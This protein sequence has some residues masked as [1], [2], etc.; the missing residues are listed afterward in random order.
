MGVINE[1]SDSVLVSRSFEIYNS[2]YVGYKWT[3][4]FAGQNGNV[5]P[6]LCDTKYL[7]STNSHYPAI[8]TMT[9]IQDG[10]LI[11]GLFGLNVTYPNIIE[12]P[13]SAYDSPLVPWNINGD[14][15]ANTL[16]NFT[17]FGLVSVNRIAYIPSTE[18]RWSGGYIWTV[19]FLERNGNIPRMGTLNKLTST[20]L[21]NTAEI[22]VGTQTQL[23]PQ[24]DPSTAVIGNQIYGTFGLEFYDDYGKLYNSTASFFNITNTDGHALS[25]EE[26]QAEFYTFFESQILVNVSRSATPNEVLGYTYLVTF[27]GQSVGGNVN[28][29]IP[30]TSN[31]L[32]TSTASA[33]LQ[34]GDI[35]SDALKCN[36]GSYYIN[37]DISIVEN[38]IGAQLQGTFQLRFN[39]YITSNIPYNADALTVEG[40][41]NDLLSISPSRVK[42]SRYGPIHTPFTQVFGFVWSITFDSNTWVD[43]TVNHDTYVDG[44]WIGS[45]TTW[46]DTWSTGYSKAWG[47]NVGDMPLIQCV[48]NGLYLTNGNLQSDSCVV[49]E[50]I[51]GTAPLAGTFKLGLNT[52]G[53]QV[54][55]V[56][57]NLYTRPISIN[58]FANAEDSG[59]DGT[60]LQE[61]LQALDNVGDISVTRSAVNPLNGGYTWYITFLRDQGGML[62]QF[63]Y[64]CQQRDSTYNLCNSPGDV[65]GL[66]FN[67]KSL[68]GECKSEYNSTI[69]YICPLVTVLTGDSNS[70]AQPPGSKA[71]QQIFTSNPNYDYNFAADESFTISYAP[72][73]TSTYETTACIP[74]TAPAN[75]VQ[76]AI[77]TGI[78][79]LNPLANSRGVSVTATYDDVFAPNGLVYTIYFFDEGPKN[80]FIVGACPGVGLVWNVTQESVVEGS[81]FGLTAEDMGVQ[82]GVVQRGDFTAFY[83]DGEPVQTSNITLAWNAPAMGFRNETVNYSIQSYIEATSTHKV[84]V[85]RLVIGKYG[86]VQYEIIFIYNEGIYPPGAGDISKLVV[87]QNPAT[88]G[89]DY[90]PQVYELVKGSAGLSGDFEVDLHDPNG[91][92]TIHFNETADR[93][94]HKL[95]EMDTVGYV[96]VE[97][98]YYPS[99]TSGGWG[100]VQVSDGT[101]GG[102]EWR[103]YFLRNPGAYNGY[104]FPPGSGNVDPLAITFLPGKSVFGT[105]VLVETIIYQEGSIPIDGA[106]TLTYDNYVTDPIRYS[107]SPLEVKY[108]LED[109]ESIGEVTTNSQNRFMQYLPGIYVTARRDSLTLEVEYDFDV[110]TT[111]TS[112]YTLDI[113]QYLSPGDLI[114]VGGINES[115]HEFG[116]LAVDGSPYLSLGLVAPEN[117]IIKLFYDNYENENII[118]PNEIL[119]I[120]ADNYT[121]IRSGIEIQLLSIECLTSTSACGDITLQFHNNGKTSQSVCIRRDDYTNKMT[122]AEALQASFSSFEA[123][124]PNGVIVTRT[125]SFDGNSFY[126]KFY[127]EGSL[128]SG[129]VNQMS[130]IEGCALFG[131]TALTP[132][133]KASLITLVQG[134]F[135][136]I[137]KLRVNVDSGY[138]KGSF[139]QL[140]ADN[141]GNSMSTSCVGYGIDSETLESEL[142]NLWVLSYQLLPISAMLI[143]TTTVITNGSIFGILDVGSKIAF[144]EFEQYTISKVISSSEFSLAEDIRN[145]TIDDLPVL[146]STVYLIPGNAVHVA[147]YGTGNST[148]TVI[149]VTQTADE[150]VSHASVGY[151]RLSIELNGNVLESNC[152]RYHSSAEDVQTAVNSMGFDINNDGSKPANHIIISRT[153]DG[154]ASSGYGYVYYFNFSGPPL[155]LSQS[156]L[157]GNSIPSINIINEGYNGGCSD[158][159]STI[160]STTIFNFTTSYNKKTWNSASSS[161]LTIIQPGDILRLIGTA[162]PF[163]TYHVYSATAQNIT[164]DKVMPMLQIENDTIQALIVKGPFA[165]YSVETVQ[166]G[167]DSYSYYIYFTGRHLSNVKQVVPTICSSNYFHHYDGSLFGVEVSTIENGG[168]S[169]YYELKLQSLVPISSSDGVYY[170]FVYNGHSLTSGFTWGAT[171]ISI[172]S[173]LNSLIDVFTA[174]VTR[175]GFGGDGEMYGYAYHITFNDIIEEIDLPLLNVLTDSEVS[176]VYYRPANYSASNEVN[177]LSVSG[178]FIGNHTARFTVYISNS[179]EEYM[180]NNHSLGPQIVFA[181]S[182][183]AIDI[184][185]NVIFSSYQPTNIT[186][187]V[188]YPL[189]YGLSIIFSSSSQ[190]NIDDEWQFV[191]LRVANILPTGASIQFS[192]NTNFT[193]INNVITVHPGYKGTAFGEVQ[194]FKVPPIYFVED[195]QNSV[196][197]L[198]TSNYEDSNPTYRL[199]VNSSDSNLFNASTVCLPWDAADYEVEAALSEA[200][201]DLCAP[202]PTPTLLTLNSNNDCVT[203]TRSVDEILNPGGY[204]YLIYLDN[205]RVSLN[206]D[207]NILDFNTSGCTLTNSSAFQ[208]R[209]ITPPIMHNLYSKYSI[210]LASSSSSEVPAAYYGVTVSRLPVYKVNGNLWSVTFNTNLGDIAPLIASKTRYLTADSNL[211]V[212]DDVVQG[213]HPTSYVIDN[214]NTGIQYSSRVTA[215]TRGFRHGYSNYSSTT[216]SIPSTKPPGISNF[217]ANTVLTVNE[218][219]SVSVA[220]SHVREIQAVTTSADEYADVQSISLTIAEGYSVAGGTF[221]MRWPD[222][223]ILQFRANEPA[224][225]DGYFKLRYLYYGPS[226]MLINETTSCLNIGADGDDVKAALEELSSIDKVEVFKSGYGG[227]TDYIGFSYSVSFVGN[228]VSGLNQLLEIYYGTD[229]DTCSNGFPSGLTILTDHSNTDFTVGLDTSLQSVVIS[230]DSSITQGSYK[231]YFRNETSDCISW[232][233]SA[234][235]FKQAL[236][237][238]STI[239][240]VLV[241]RFGSGDEYSSYGYTYN[242]YF[243]GNGLMRYHYYD[244]LVIDYNNSC[245]YFGYVSNGILTPFGSSVSLSVVKVTDGGFTLQSSNTT[246]IQ[247]KNDFNFLPS[248]IKVNDTRRSL[249]DDQSGYHY[250]ILFQLSMGDVPSLVCGEDNYLLSIGAACYHHTVI[251]GNYL[252]GYFIIGT[253]E[254]LPFDISADALAT[255][256]SNL[257]DIGT[258][259][260]TRSSADYQGGYTWTITWMTV[261]GNH[262]TLQ[263]SSSLFGSGATVSVK[264]IQDGD[265]LSGTYRLGYDGL[266]TSTI[267]FNATATIVKSALN[268]IVG[269]VSVVRSSVDTEGGSTYQITFYGLR[270]NIALLS[271]YYDQTLFGINPVVA[272]REIKPGSIASGSM[273]SLSFDS[274][275]YCSNS[276]VLL[277]SCGSPIDEYFIDYGRTKNSFTNTITILPDYSIQKVRIAATSLYDTLYFTGVDATGYFKL[278]Y[279]GFTTDPISSYASA[280]DLRDALESLTPI[281]VVSV[282]RDYSSDLVNGTVSAIPGYQELTC[283]DSSCGFSALVP[284]ELIRVGGIWYKISETY[285]GS[286][287]SL[288]LALV[289]D[290]SIVT[291]YGGLTLSNAPLYRWARGYEWT[292]TFYS[293]ESTSVLP[294]ASVKHGLNPPDATVAIRANDCVNCEFV[295]QLSSF[296]QYFFRISGHNVDGYGSLTSTT[297]IPKDIPAAPNS[298]SLLVLSGTELEVFFSY[299]SGIISDITEYIVQWDTNENMTDVVNSL[300]KASCDTIGYGQCPVYGASISGSPPF[301]YLIQNLKIYTKYF[302]R[303]CALNSLSSLVTLSTGIIVN[304]NVYWSQ[305]V[306]AITSNQ[307]PSAPVSVITLTSGKE[308]IQVLISPPA[309]DGGADVSSY[310]IEYD[311]SSTYDTEYYGVSNVSV[312]NSSAWNIVSNTTNGVYFYEI[313]NLVTGVSYYVRV[314]AQNSYGHSTKQSALGTVTPAGKADPPGTVL[315]TTNSTQTT[316]ITSAEIQWTLPQSNGGSTITGYKIEWWQNASLPDI[317]IV[318]YISNFYPI[319][320]LGQFKLSFG[321]QTTVKN[322]T[323]LLSQNTNQYDLRSELIN[324]GYNEL[325]V[326]SDYL[327]GNVMVT[328][329]SVIGKG[330]AWFVTFISDLNQGNQVLMQPS[331]SLP[332]S[333]SH[334]SVTVIKK[335][336][337]QR[338]GGFHEIQLISILAA[339]TNDTS[340]LIGSFRLSFNGSEELSPYLSVHATALQV[341]R[342]MNQL[343]SIQG[344][345]TVT[346]SEVHE[347]MSNLL[348]AG[349]NWRVTF[350]DGRGDLPIT[351]IQSDL[352]SST[353]AG[354]IAV[355]YDGNNDVNPLTGYKAYDTYIGELPVN[356]NYVYVNS[357]QRSFTITGLTPGNTYSATVST[358]NSYGTGAP[359]VPANADLGSINP[360]LQVPQ[361]PAS[362]SVST[363]P[364]S[365]T[366]LDVTYTQPL[367]NGGAPILFYRVEVDTDVYFSNPI[368]NIIYCSTSNPH[369]VY[370]ITTIGQYQDPIVSGSF[371]LMISYNGNKYYTGDISYETPALLSDEIG[372]GTIIS[373]VYGMIDVNSTG[374]VASS[375][376]S[377]LIFVGDRLQFPSHQLFPALIYTV[378]NVQNNNITVDNPVYTNSSSS[379]TVVKSSIARYIGGRGTAATSLITCISDVTLCPASRLQLPGS[380][381]M[382][383]KIN[384]IKELTVLGV[385]VDRVGPDSYNG[386][387]WRVTF[388][389]NSPVDPTKNFKISVYSNDVLLSSGAS[390]NLTVTNLL[391]GLVY[392]ACEGTFQIPQNQLLINGQSYYARVFAVNEIGYS[393]PMTSSTSQKPMVVPNAPTSVSLSVLSSTE[394][395]VTFNPPDYDGGDTII[396]YKIEYSTSSTFSAATTQTA[397]LTN[398][399][400]GSPYQKTLSN[401]VTGTFYHIRVSAANSQGY[402][403]TTLSTPNSLNPY[404]TSDVPTNVMLYV[405]SDTMLTVSFGLP[406]NNGGDA[407]SAYRV[408]WDISATFNGQVSYPDKGYVDLS[409]TYYSSYT[410]QYLTTGQKYYVRVYAKNSAGLGTSLQSTPSY[411]I[412][413]LQ[414][415]GKPHTIYAKT[416]SKSG[417]IT[418]TWQYPRIPWHNVPCSGLLN[419][420]NDCPSKVGAVNG[421]PDSTGGSALL[422]YEISYN[423]LEDFSGFDS[424]IEVTSGSNTYYTLQYLTPGRLYYIRVLARNAQGSGAYC[425]Y[426]EQ[427]CLIVFVHASAVAGVST[428]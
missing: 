328:K 9:T 249:P 272:V 219:Q 67:I 144:N 137:Q 205:V 279:N 97:R 72:N 45:A 96:Y 93:L 85:T 171:A 160:S 100:G 151:F 241:E 383:G 173:N 5:K 259:A 46:S 159:N 410:I 363:H 218:V 87:H 413:M 131:S 44:N 329:S 230:A 227:Y 78:S 80:P 107:Q 299:P 141:Y 200:Y 76:N 202:S 120:G 20:P 106:F 226:W 2:S 165:D 231:V 207:A 361:P 265:T 215:Y 253:S 194:V 360:A 71:V 223:Q 427:N 103:I 305:V 166:Q 229:E 52:I 402:G 206:V 376:V 327:I 1:I 359:W 89:I 276:Q 82:N 64:D 384:S 371:S 374:I 406:L 204:V 50:Y 240:S 91:P 416:G 286:S 109:L 19:T 288:P 243:N 114:R 172:Q 168:S 307:P 331:Q 117:P 98:Y 119:R 310:V 386:Y 153:G 324:M 21:G 246:A 146:F 418:L 255:A 350:N 425:A 190:R 197:R 33:S 358:V 134:G 297:G 421:L 70:S 217:V 37:K 198:F 176:S 385:D 84:D 343:D 264:T 148:S 4:T 285:K 236:E 101:Y 323:N 407:I 43:P 40:Q 414:I 211:E 133:T 351:G 364:G 403:P 182:W 254:F 304:D 25:A 382:Q 424:G 150:F 362:V 283:D 142:Q 62:G 99:S 335:Q 300:N 88:N 154:T 311:S 271:A 423:E 63:G 366:S 17:Y 340:A 370:K 321:P 381:S 73:E 349:Y 292:I 51:Q 140:S 18:Y 196:F 92:R 124:G 163:A 102:Y 399:S 233:A 368:H 293:T 318:Q 6:L 180:H 122:S 116:Q 188:T 26:L 59:G 338:N 27:I 123:V 277:G 49:Y 389:D 147:R 269:S 149:K 127:F 24:D 270:G 342:A 412:P 90:P 138:I 411:S 136:E 356:Y 405:T 294:L 302:V 195:Q 152:L 308:C 252:S 391:N 398:L 301:S 352:I 95:N 68:N 53:N 237:R 31:L 333:Q 210:P 32:A 94:A 330:Y 394:L 221:T 248:F 128:V 13:I 222:V 303:V 312:T 377:E 225:L 81:Y 397:Y 262:S 139:F 235:E 169:S 426:I 282:T 130:L 143:D 38:V 126:F 212:F 179:Y 395:K 419:A 22:Y 396:A 344:Y 35:C 336:N 203:V 341:E 309:T 268:N 214:L 250:T 184:S 58:A 115:S 337:G 290:S 355:I 189:E 428:N 16:S 129:N 334:E 422:Q 372:Q 3:I 118:L 185:D 216:S 306:S 174:A 369:T 404:Q 289:N 162:S 193:S 60:S 295:D 378:V 278:S 75:V 192:S 79:Y 287:T 400:S 348:Y 42:V 380:S 161:L 387:T 232:D 354:F 347:T 105:G 41:L 175:S 260:V 155:E 317:Q 158:L 367:S 178:S 167:E 280:L 316:P 256:L 108:F 281:N 298:V 28:N 247:L 213:L 319:F 14:Y 145:I 258:V 23:L 339:Q 66:E 209:Q 239:D 164:V 390:A 113:R 74:V 34:I 48:D 375:D 104:T 111:N 61:K 39:G 393:L 420:P 29:F 170:Y 415:P 266:I 201:V 186:A 183:F 267:P 357:L 110:S 320:E 314:S 313:C 30:I 401:L 242:V 322:T 261:P 315:I 251:E 379:T 7:T 47:K 86:V 257:N 228:N 234:N 36:I 296:T 77:T 273:L 135:T 244:K 125:T 238:I 220:G 274:P 187:D 353:S 181:F 191:A 121:V 15:L 275:L 346:R 408:E 156:N 112:D 56:Q 199:S 83:V 409:S 284:G 11:D 54:I 157:L 392:D 345:V 57:K 177:D 224:E 8:C 132:D 326:A 373:G 12:G 388:L 291:Y 245:D 10:S 417:E 332:S 325:Q 263:V 65:P 69:P 365:A 208:F 55:N